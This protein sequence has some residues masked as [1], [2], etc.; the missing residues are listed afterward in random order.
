MNVGKVFTN[1]SFYPTISS[2]SGTPVTSSEKSGPN[3]FTTGHQLD[4]QHV[5]EYGP[6]AAGNRYFLPL[7]QRAYLTPWFSRYRNHDPS[8]FASG[9]LSNQP[10]SLLNPQQ[11]LHLAD[12]RGLA[13]H[14]R[15]DR[16]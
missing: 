7:N 4:K 3:F 2:T 16:S 15:S 11:D 6:D 5:A 13:P 12:P 14:F 10:R 1:Y 8:W 9:V